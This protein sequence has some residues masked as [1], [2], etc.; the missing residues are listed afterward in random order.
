[1][2]AQQPVGRMHAGCGRLGRWKRPQRCS[3]VVARETAWGI[4][5]SSARLGRQER[6]HG[7]RRYSGRDPGETRIMREWCSFASDGDVVGTVMLVLFLLLLLLPHFVVV[8]AVCC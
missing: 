7:E 2:V 6:P 5:P 1:M 4:Q 8:V 3:P